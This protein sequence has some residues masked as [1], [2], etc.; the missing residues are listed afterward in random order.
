[1]AIVTKLAEHSEL[2]NQHLLFSTNSKSLTLRI[3]E[4]FARSFVKGAKS[5]PAQQE[6]QLASHQEFPATLLAEL[7]VEEILLI[8]KQGIQARHS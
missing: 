8:F 7:V 1:M 4:S 5:L 2:K 3:G 6:R